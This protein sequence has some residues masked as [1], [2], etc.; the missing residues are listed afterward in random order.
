MST[1]TN[2]LSK[3]PHFQHR[4]GTWFLSHQLHSNVTV[5]E[6]YIGCGADEPWREPWLMVLQGHFATALLEKMKMTRNL[7]SMWSIHVG[8][9]QT[10]YCLCCTCAAWTEFVCSWTKAPLM[11]VLLVCH[12]LSAF[13]GHT[14]SP[15]LT[16][17]I[18]EGMAAKENSF[19]SILII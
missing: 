10:N 14:E 2:H 11:S 8:L 4:Q 15:P 16:C 3:L 7:G 1:L 17:G 6:V 13:H 19:F 12:I 9:S 18:P 5:R